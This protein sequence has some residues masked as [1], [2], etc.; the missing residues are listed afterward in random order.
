MDT[1]ATITALEAELQAAWA[2][3]DGAGAEVLRARIAELWRQRR[4][5]LAQRP[6]NTARDWG[7]RI[8]PRTGRPHR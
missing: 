7:W 1:L 5:E 2:R 4:A 3:R 8:D 6:V